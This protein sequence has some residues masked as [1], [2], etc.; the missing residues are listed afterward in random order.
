MIRMHTKF[1]SESLEGR[2]HLED[3]VIDGKLI[4]KWILGKQ[5]VKCGMDISGSNQGSVAGCCEHSNEPL[6]SIKRQGI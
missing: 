6:G 3:L 5:G 2:D 4:L 1:W